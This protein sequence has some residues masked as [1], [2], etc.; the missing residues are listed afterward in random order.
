MGGG[1]K[2]SCGAKMIKVVLILFNFLFF[3]LGIAIL[4]IGIYVLVDPSFKQIKNIANSDVIDLASKS[5]IN[6]T[7]IDKC[8]IAFCIF[9]GFMFAISF[10]GC[11]GAMR[12]IKCLLGM[13]STILLVLLLAEIGMGI[14][15]AVYSAKLKDLLVPLLRQ[16][17]KDQYMGDMS[18]KTLT[19]VAWDAVNFNFE[20]CGASNASDFDQLNNVWTERFGAQLP[21]SCCKFK[22]RKTDW[23]GVIPNITTENGYPECPTAPNINN[24]YVSIGCYDRIKGLI[25]QYSVIVIA[26]A[27]GIGL[28]LLMGVIFGFFLCKKVDD[29]DDYV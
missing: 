28:I 27:I 3:L 29:L 10:L 8:G 20:C 15:A 5:G 12:H 17:I 2:L 9:G 26:V 16:S 7:Y 13:Y 24:S 18:N 1:P 4:A 22:N 6:L 25:D 14:F 19:S 11:C 21:R 23:S